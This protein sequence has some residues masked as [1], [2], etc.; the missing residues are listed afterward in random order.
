MVPLGFVRYAVPEI[1]DARH[2]EIESADQPSQI[3]SYRHSWRL[4]PLTKEDWH[5][6]T[7]VILL[8][9]LPSPM[10]S[11]PGLLL[12]AACRLVPQAYKSPFL[13]VLFSHDFPFRF[14]AALDCCLVF[15]LVSFHAFPSQL[16]IIGCR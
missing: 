1:H 4:R 6:F 14:W 10:I 16:V 7:A 11:L 12:A 8:L 15:Q 3:I 5:R 2:S 13:I 9:S